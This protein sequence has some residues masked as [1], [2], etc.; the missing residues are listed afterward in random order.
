MGAFVLKD[1]FISIN[2]VDL[3]D[4]VMSATLNYSAD[5]Q[6]D[7][8]MGDGTRTR[9]AG[10]KDWS[11]DVTFKQDFDS[12]SVDD[13]L[14]SLV[15]AAAVPIIFRPVKSTAVGPTNPNFSGNA[16]LETYPPTSNAVGELSQVSVTLQAAGTLSRATS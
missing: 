6:E 9:L 15:G 1:A 11:L 14:F 13:T 10:L 12:G 4:H 8:A 5:L 16:V 2:G 3:S 7:T